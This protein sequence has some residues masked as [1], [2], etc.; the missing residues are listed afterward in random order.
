MVKATVAPAWVSDWE[1]EYLRRAVAEIEELRN[2]IP[3]M[4]QIVLYPS[5]AGAFVFDNVAPLGGET[6]R[7]RVAIEFED[8][9]DIGE[10]LN[11]FKAK[12]EAV[13]T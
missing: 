5:G 9:D 11:Q 6:I 10:C 12:V 1:R 2:R 8:D 4:Y 13:S 3:G 7:G